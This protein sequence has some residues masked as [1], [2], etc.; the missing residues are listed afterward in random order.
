M[1]MSLALA[2]FFWERMPVLLVCVFL[3][4]VHSAFFGPSKYGLLPELLPE[5]KLSWGNGLLELGTFTAIILGTVTAGLM[6]EHSRGHHGLSGAILI[7]LAAIGLMFSLGITRVPAADPYR[8]FNANFIQ[9]LFSQMLSWRGDRPLILAVLGILPFFHSFGFMGTLWLRP[10]LELEWCIIQKCLMEKP[11][12]RLCAILMSR[13]C[14]QPRRFSRFTCAVARLSN[15][16]LHRLGEEPLR[17][18]LE[19]LAKSN[20]PNLWKPRADRFIRVETF[21]YLGTG[22]LDLRR[23]REMAEQASAHES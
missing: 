14:C 6:A 13:S 1:V 16:V 8:K 23:I 21:P 10:L 4:G 22:K 2:G 7:V 11:L 15:I 12:V 17:C 3:M 19:K 9:S 18:C 20:L 5:K